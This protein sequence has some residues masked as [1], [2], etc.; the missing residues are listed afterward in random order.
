MFPPA[1]LDL[2]SAV[3]NYLE[4]QSGPDA[5]ALGRFVVRAG[6]LPGLRLELARS[7]SGRP[8]VP[9]SVLLGAPGESDLTQVNALGGGNEA[10]ALAEAV[11]IRGDLALLERVP[12][13]WDRYFEVPLDGGMPEAL[14]AIR[15][16]GA[17]AKVRTGGIVAEAFP[18]PDALTGFLLH[19]ARLRLPFKATAGLHH[20]VRGSYRLTYEPGAPC[21][22]MFGFLN[23]ALAAAVA[24]S[25]GDG[26]DTRAALVEDEEGAMHWDS[27]GIPWRHHRFSAQAIDQLRRDF[28][29]GFGSCSFRE[30]LDEL[31]GLGRVR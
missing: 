13:S 10:R 18:D 22:T 21:G 31:A 24:W 12:P 8:P 19:A 7:G 26:R 23:V 15:R 14:E 11:E 20:P 4:Y 1:G 28:F 5:W 27:G 3:A 2:S 6:D 16:G 25:T 29:H 30:P 9:L 17:F